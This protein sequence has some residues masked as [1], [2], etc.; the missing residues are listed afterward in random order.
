MPEK[1][2]S[3]AVD[4]DDAR[5]SNYYKGIMK[6]EGGS[7]KL[8]KWDKAMHARLRHE[9]GKPWTDI[10][11]NKF[12]ELTT[13][14]AKQIAQEISLARIDPA[15]AKKAFAVLPDAFVTLASQQ[16]VR[17]KIFEEIY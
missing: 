17:Q 12:E 14:N 16:V 7:E 3:R 2:I 5:E 1:I 15:D 13:A 10:W 6:Y 11:E 9:G 8:E 4:P